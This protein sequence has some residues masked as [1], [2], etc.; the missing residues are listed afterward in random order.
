MLAEK[1]RRELEAVVSADVKG[2][3]R[4]KDEDNVVAAKMGCV[5]QFSYR[6]LNNGC[7]T[8]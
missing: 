6:S 3:S 4:L 1:F 2:Y 7:Q 8:V 5:H